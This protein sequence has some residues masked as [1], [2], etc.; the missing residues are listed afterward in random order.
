MIEPQGLGLQ[1]WRAAPSVRVVAWLRQRHAPI[2]WP[3]L[4]QL[5]DALARSGQAAAVV[6]GLSPETADQ[7]GLAQWVAYGERP[8]WA[9]APTTAD[10]PT[11]PKLHRLRSHF[12][13]QALVAQQQRG[14]GSVA[15]ALAQALRDTPVLIV[16]AQLDLGL[17]L[18]ADSAVLPVLAVRGGAEQA[19]YAY[20]VLKT[21]RL[22]TTT[23]PLLVCA[24]P[25]PGETS[26]AQALRACS[27]QYLHRDVDTVE[28]PINRQGQWDSAAPKLLA[29]KLLD[30]SRTIKPWRPTWVPAHD[31][32]TRADAWSAPIAR[33]PGATLDVHRQGPT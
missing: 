31:D 25:R 22:T 13:L 21:V 3:L 7:P 15:R 27:R 16:V 4:Q 6:D 2:E 26:L 32:V 1:R 33:P 10:N 28:L 19:V 12:G 5:C 30:K 20:E 24:S 9:P 29:R 8:A 11:R 23:D 18:L 14:E 17:P